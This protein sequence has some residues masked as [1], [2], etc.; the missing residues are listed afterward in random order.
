ML[1]SA[2]GGAI[3]LDATQRQHL[4]F[5]E[6]RPACSLPPPALCPPRPP[7]SA[8]DATDRL[9]PW[10]AQTRAWGGGAPPPLAM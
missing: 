8:L 10:A 5:G 1:A 3:A 4:F 2:A 6:I 7:R 9:W